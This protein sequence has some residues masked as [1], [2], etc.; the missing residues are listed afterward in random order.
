MNGGDNNRLKPGAVAQLGALLT[1]ILASACCWLPL[2]LLGFGLSAGGLAAKFEA[3]RPVFLPVTFGLLGL[4]FYFAYRKPQPLETESPAR[5]KVGKGASTGTDPCCIAEQPRSLNLNKLNKATLWVVTASVL[6]LA[7][8]PNYVG[9]FLRGGDTAQTVTAAARAE[10]TWTLTIE[11]MT[12]EACAASIESSLRKV[13]GVSEASVDYPTG[14]AVVVAAP[15]VGED[16]LREAVEAAGY[17]VASTQRQI[18]GSEEQNER[19]RERLSFR[20]AG[21]DL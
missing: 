10:R 19:Q 21:H 8:F 7:L 20:R 6:A 5:G 13:P 11:G 17:S 15:T 2:L 4:A 3:A 14:R 9:F 16:Q 12:C 18:T 1:A